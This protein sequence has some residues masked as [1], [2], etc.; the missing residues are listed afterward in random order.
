MFVGADTNANVVVCTVGK[1][2]L[3]DLEN[4]VIFCGHSPHSYIQGT[5]FGQRCFHDVYLG[6]HMRLCNFSPCELIS[7]VF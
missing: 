1:L 4:R 7:F 3:V 2:D 6:Q 5:I